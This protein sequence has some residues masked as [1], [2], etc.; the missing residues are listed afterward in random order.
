M[1][2]LNSFLSSG[3]GGEASY[4]SYHKALS[5]LK[6]SLHLAYPASLSFATTSIPGLL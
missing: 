3:N 4:N 6:T 2:C 1:Y 5:Q